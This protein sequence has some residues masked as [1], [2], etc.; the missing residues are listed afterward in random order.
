MSQNYYNIHTSAHSASLVYP[1]ASQEEDWMTRAMT[2]ARDN[3]EQMLLNSF[4]QQ[5]VSSHDDDLEPLPL[6]SSW[7]TNFSD[8][9]VSFMSQDIM[10]YISE[11]ENDD[12]PQN[13][14]PT[15]PTT[16]TSSSRLDLPTQVD[17][18]CGQ[19]RTCADH[20]GNKRFQVVLDSY[21]RRYHAATTKQEKMVMTKEI[22]ACIKETGS[23]FLKYSQGTWI[24]ITD[25]AARD[26]V[27][28][29][30]RTKAASWKRQEDK[31]K[32]YQ[33]AN[34]PSSISQKSK[35]KTHRRRVSNNSMDST[36]SNIPTNSFDSNHARS[37]PFIESLMQNQKDIFE[38]MTANDEEVHPLLK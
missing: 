2:D 27:S 15:A 31:K 30:L 14:I 23:R 5:Q 6:H 17:I 16:L 38:I 20:T 32:A 35:R 29:A 1:I 28:H 10:D 21:A 9:A 18:L 36:T 13:D 22:V 3:R 33:V 8:S 24:E 7:N 19:S 25:V 4:A 26:K 12:E 34:K 11:P 37:S